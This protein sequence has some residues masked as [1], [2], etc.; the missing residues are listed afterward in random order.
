M[1]PSLVPQFADATF[2][3]YRPWNQYS[4]DTLINNRIF[5]SSPSDVNDPYDCRFPDLTKP[6]PAQFRKYLEFQYLHLRD[7]YRDKSMVRGGLVLLDAYIED[8]EESWDET[9]KGAKELIINRSSFCSLSEIGDSPL[10]FAHY[11]DG[12][13]GICFQFHFS[14]HYA[15]AHL[16]IV[17]YEKSFGEL[18]LFN[19]EE[20]DD[21]SLV[22]AA[23]YR[24][25]TDW[26]YEREWRAFRY[27]KPKGVV[28]F[29]PR[30]LSGVILGCKM[31]ATDKNEVVSII[32]SRPHPIQVYE[33]VMS[34][35]GIGLVVQKIAGI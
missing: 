3:K 20:C 17:V 6:T 19:D 18:D 10:M 28:N 15:L 27:H 2:Y 13:K 11:G 23:I 8:R 33:A 26:E 34:A 31:S 1:H 22:Q 7:P 9:I 4:K 14:L 16:E 21:E 30:C 25:S 29:D 5:F 35:S 24:K 32:K 12:H